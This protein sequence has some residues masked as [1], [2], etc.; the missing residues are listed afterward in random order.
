M[1][2]SAGTRRG[3]ISFNQIAC[4]T[5]SSSHLSPSECLEASIDKND[6]FYF[7]AQ[8]CIRGDLA[9]CLPTPQ[10]LQPFPSAV[11]SPLLVPH[12][13][14]G[15]LQKGPLKCSL[16]TSIPTLHALH[17]GF[18]GDPD[19]TLSTTQTAL[20]GTTST[21]SC[22]FGFPEDCSPVSAFPLTSTPSSPMIPV[23]SIGESAA[24]PR[25]RASGRYALYSPLSD[26]A[27]VSKSPEHLSRRSSLRL[28]PT[29]PDNLKSLDSKTLD[30]PLLPDFSP[31]TSKLARSTEARKQ[32]A[33][34]ETTKTAASQNIALGTD[35]VD[36]PTHGSLIS[37][38]TPSPDNMASQNFLW[39][40]L[41]TWG[42]L[43]A[44]ST[45][46]PIPQAAPEGVKRTGS[47][48]S[49]LRVVSLHRTSLRSSTQ[50]NSREEHATVIDSAATDSTEEVSAAA[51]KTVQLAIQESMHS[52]LEKT[53]PSKPWI[54]PPSEVA[55]ELT[56]L[57]IPNITS[58]TT[59]SRSPRF[60]YVGPL[61]SYRGYAK[62]SDRVSASASY[63]SAEGTDDETGYHESAEYLYLP[64][65]TVSRLRCFSKW[66]GQI[67]FSVGSVSLVAVV[68][69]AWVLEVSPVIDQYLA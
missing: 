54:A 62:S 2:R 49:R 20:P 7:S 26:N 37:S 24:E 40:K 63:A 60:S 34:Y 28:S 43:F 6:A 18:R 45:S 11:A 42:W 65:K 4:D 39:N 56:S 1:G 23:P 16:D 5:P 53:L 44:S 59:P 46:Q 55:A 12:S 19:P 64:T 22:I 35:S 9:D 57:Q 32:Q 68:L 27:A 14:E 3:P 51:C 25:H 58:N 29:F 13:D 10:L 36:S 17:H 15:E 50:L 21:E 69:F 48:G 33:L 47:T 31:C 38:D 61:H 30:D 67:G 8:G 66:F 41:Q 52:T